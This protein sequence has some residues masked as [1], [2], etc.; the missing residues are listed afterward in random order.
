MLLDGAC[1]NLGRETKRARE[2]DGFPEIYPFSWA[3]RAVGIFPVFSGCSA[4][5]GHARRRIWRLAFG[6]GGEALA[7]LRAQGLERIGRPDHDFEV[8]DLPRVVEFDQIDAVKRPVADARRELE[9]AAGSI[10]KFANVFEILE[11]RDDG[12]EDHLHGV[13][14]FIGLPCSQSRSGS[15]LKSRSAIMACHRARPDLAA[16]CKGPLALISLVILHLLE[17]SGRCR[18]HAPARRC[19]TNCRAKGGSSAKLRTQIARSRSAQGSA[20]VTIAIGWV[21]AARRAVVCGTMPIRTLQATSRHT[22][23]KLRSCT[24][25]RSTRPM[26]AAFAAR[27]RCSAL[28]RSSPTKSWSSTR[29]NA[30]LARLASGWSRATTSTNRSRRNGNVSSVPASTVPATMPISPTPSAIRPTISSL[31]RSSK[32]TLTCGCAERNELSAS[33]RNSVSALVFENTRIWPARPPA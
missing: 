17:P 23:S 10:V 11:D 25:S 15:P 18:A 30:I 27:K 16:A 5:P 22:A 21:L 24:R 3:Y 1:D 29:A 31:S 13:L 12:T 33:G 4:D 20:S 8:D 14:A 9:H 26:R 19:S 2:V 6:P 28:P 32:S 7:H